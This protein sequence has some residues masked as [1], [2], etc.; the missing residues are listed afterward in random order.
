MS[1][2]PKKYDASTIKV[3]EGIDAV[4]KRPDMYIG[5]TYEYGLHHLV[6]EVVDNSIDE[7]Q[8]GHATEVVVTI[9]TDQ[10]VSVRD[11]GRGIPCGIH[12]TEG[13][14]AVEIVMTKLHAGGKFS[15]DNYK[16]SGG[17]HGVGVSVVNFL[18]EWVE[19]EVCQ[20]GKVHQLRFERGVTARPMSIAGDTDRTGTKLRFKPDHEIFS[21]TEFDATTL[22]TRL[23]ELAFLNAGVA[24]TFID[25]RDSSEHHYRYEDGIIA[26]VR[27]LNEKRNAIHEDIIYFQAEKGAVSVEVALQYNDSYSDVT[28]TFANTINTREGGS[29]LSGFKTALTRTMNNYGRQ[30]GLIKDGKTLSG[31]DFREGLASVISVRLPEPKFESQ[32]KIKLAN[33]D[34]QGI[35]ET[36]VA[37]QLAQYLEENPN[38][39][40]AVIRKA[41]DA[42]AAREAARRARE[43]VRRK[44]A[45]GGA[46]LPGKLSDCS[47]RDRDRSELFLVE[48]D[49]A[50]GSAKQGRD[51]RYQAILPLKGKILN[52]EKARIDKMLGHSEIRTIITA[53]GTGI[54]TDDFD[55]S[56]LRYKNVIIM[57]DADVDGS[58]IRTLLLTFFYRQMPQLVENGHIYIAQPP[59]YKIKQKS[60]ERYVKTDGE[61]NAMLFEVGT[62]RARFFRRADGIDRA[63]HGEEL[64]A[65]CRAIADLQGQR[66]GLMRRGVDLL[67]YLGLARDGALPGVML[68]FRGEEHFV[69][70]AEEERSIVAGWRES[71]GRET[72]VV[73]HGELPENPE[74]PVA[75]R[76]EI[77]E[78]AVLERSL[79]SLAAQGLS[80]A[81]LQ[82]RS[83]GYADPDSSPF[84]IDIEGETSALFELG[85][86]PEIVRKAGSK[87]LEIQR[88]KGLGE[89]NPEQLWETTMD[90]ETRTL[91]KVTV[92]DIGETDN[93]F[94]VLM[95]EAVAPRR[96]FIEENA[97]DVKQVD[98]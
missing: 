11:N 78:R 74:F 73:E 38:T 2:T 85:E 22:R 80:A 82:V 49:S 50:G 5:D 32:T 54:G 36:L 25:E 20:D 3:L 87:G 12:P 84:C 26:F 51:R 69:H 65:L 15:D 37:E 19:L 24:I 7:A 53:L 18:S 57:T 42:S 79:R 45:L 71:E 30:L 92:E 28:Y 89:M 47:S 44:G 33:R 95:G 96:E 88:Y 43:L 56:K 60:N 93:M 29:H 34:I 46:G 10:S 81:D 14:P 63:L 8:N 67:S 59:L 48:G 23:R 83:V 66:L 91:L 98:V 75:T 70:T 17:L 77:H 76:V 72:E 21:T 97:L 16:V 31:E 55:L 35:V 94:N 58:H 40:K 86:L 62:Q 6:Y 39:A 1:D 52:V 4:R 90:P 27:H 9:H 13:K 41:V 64:G 61:M 68:R